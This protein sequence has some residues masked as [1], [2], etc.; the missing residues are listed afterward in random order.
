MRR[1][2]SG[3]GVVYGPKL[4]EDD[5]KRMASKKYPN[6]MSPEGTFSHWFLNNRL[7]HLWITMVR[8]NARL[9]A[10]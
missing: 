6:M 9:S 10:I 8:F 4:S 2:D 1:T 3:V 5:K 7:I